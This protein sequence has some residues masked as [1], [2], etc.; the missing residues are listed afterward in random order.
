ME[1]GDCF[2][3]SSDGYADQNDK[4]DLKFGSHKLKQ[5]IHD[6]AHL[7]MKEQG[8]IIKQK[9]DQHKGKEAQRDDIAIIGVRIS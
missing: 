5:L 4:N 2:Y 3:L 7:P 9:F 6:V 8:N 1:E